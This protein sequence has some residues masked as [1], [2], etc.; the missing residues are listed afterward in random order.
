MK[1]RGSRNALVALALVA[2]QGADAGPSEPGV[3][4]FEGTIGTESSPNQ[5]QA[6]AAPADAPG[7]TANGNGDE[8]PAGSV[9]LVMSSTPPS[10]GQGNAENAAGTTPPAEMQPSTQPA[11]MQPPATQ[12]ADTQPPTM[13][14]PAMQPAEM[15]PPATQP[16]AMQMMPPANPVPTS[17]VVP[18]PGCGKSGRPQGGT[19]TVA[20]DHIYRFP[21]TYDGKTPMPLIMA[22][23]ANANPNTQLADITRGSALDNNYVMAFGKSAGQGWVLNT[24]SPRIDGWY[25]DL[26]NNYCIDESRVFATGHSSGAQLIV[27]LLCRGETRFKAVAPVASSM[28]CARWPALP[29]LLI[30]GANDMERA[31]TN[32]DANGRKDLGP[33]LAS[34]ACSMNTAGYNVATC[35][36]QNGGGQ[37]NPGC[38]RYQGCS[39]P[40]IWCNHNDPNYSGT[41]HGWPCFANQAIFDFLKSLP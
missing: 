13:Q 5:P 15:Q 21:A 14:P 28:Y 41:N 29:T 40:M 4:A 38:V 22:F 7:A 33:Y 9:P 24:D 25:K 10:G 32:Q 12:P 23:H 37:V 17:S 18:S 27:Q 2:C 8:G 19:V 36:S 11:D 34:N 1:I 26:L 31:N 35:Q 16:P 3:P 20:N 6:P 30:H 39:E